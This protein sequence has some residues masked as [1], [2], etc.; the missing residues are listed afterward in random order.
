[1]SEMKFPLG[2]DEIRKFLP[3]RFPFLLVD[4]ILSI[5]P[6]GPTDRFVPQA[7]VG[8]EVIGLKNVTQNEAYFQGHFP[9][10]SVNPGVL[11]IEIAA[12]VACFAYMPYFSG[13]GTKPEDHLCLLAGVNQARFRKPVV[14]GDALIVEAK[15]VKCRGS[16]AVFECEIKVEGK[17]VMEAELIT[18]L[19]SAGKV[20]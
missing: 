5:V 19:V 11:L 18:S 17:T 10:R 2:A 20:E 8:T 4:R 7:L 16:I 15:I 14:P 12:Q 9:Q 13:S 1:M 6:G 3:H